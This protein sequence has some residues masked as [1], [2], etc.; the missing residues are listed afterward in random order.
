MAFFIISLFFSVRVSRRLHIP[1][2]TQCRDMVNLIGGRA[3][4]SFY[5]N[6]NFTDC[7]PENNKEKATP[8]IISLMLGDD[9]L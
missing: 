3:Y 1:G 6:S 4:L 7:V 2:N 9:V 5:S 8:T